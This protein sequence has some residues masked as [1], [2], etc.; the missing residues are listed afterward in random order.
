MFN[1]LRVSSFVIVGSRIGFSHYSKLELGGFQKP[2]EFLKK[3]WDLGRFEF[4]EDPRIVWIDVQDIPMVSGFFFDN[5]EA[6]PLKC[7]VGPIVVFEHD[8]LCLLSIR[9][10]IHMPF[11][12]RAF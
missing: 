4:H 1:S 8:G 9:F 7:L 3:T 5:V 12:L 2:M 11:H 10:P 6:D